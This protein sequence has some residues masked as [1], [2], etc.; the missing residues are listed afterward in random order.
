MKSLPGIMTPCCSVRLD[1]YQDMPVRD[2]ISRARL[3]RF[4]Q[5]VI[6]NANVFEVLIDAV[7]VC[8]LGQITSAL[9]EVSRQYRRSL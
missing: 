4:Q 7:R 2:P 8:S 6:D 9:C 1:S 3:Q 5:A